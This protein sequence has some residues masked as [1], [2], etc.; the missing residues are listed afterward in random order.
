MVK[1]KTFSES[2]N[3]FDDI[4]LLT[5]SYRI[6]HQIKHKIKSEMGTLGEPPSGS[7]S[8]P[9]GPTCLFSTQLLEFNPTIPRKK[10]KA[11]TSTIK[12]GPIAPK[13]NPS[14]FKTV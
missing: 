1:E 8:S 6:N 7:V 9:N 2:P 3:A 12:V 11:Y 4:K 5:E 10:I 13:H 14:N